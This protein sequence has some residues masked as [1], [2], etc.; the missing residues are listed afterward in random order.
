MVATLKCKVLETD[1]TNC[2]ADV[3]AFL[4]TLG[5]VT[6]IPTIAIEG[7]TEKFRVVIM[8]VEG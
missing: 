3:T 2:Q 7:T 4:A 1:S 5:T 6:G 8:Y